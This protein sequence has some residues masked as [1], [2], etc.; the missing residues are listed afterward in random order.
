MN[1]RWLFFPTGALLFAC[2]RCATSDPV[3]AAAD[4]ASDDA[5]EFMDSGK[6][7]ATPE[8]D[9]A[10]VVPDAG[11][12]WKWFAAF[13]PSCTK[14]SVPIDP[15]K[16]LPAITWNACATATPFSSGTT[17]CVEWDWASMTMPNTV[18]K[19]GASVSGDGK[20]L[21][22]TRLRESSASMYDVEEDLYRVE[23]LQ[24]L[25][26]WRFRNPN[27][28][29]AD[30]YDPCLVTVVTAGRG[31]PFLHAS[32]PAF[33]ASVSG[34]LDELMNATSYDRLIPELLP[35]PNVANS[36]SASDTVE[37]FLPFYGE[38]V[39]R[40]KRSDMSWV[41][42]NVGELTRPLVVK[43][44]VFARDRNTP[45]YRLARVEVNGDVT[46]VRDVAAHHVFGL[47]DDGTS[48]YWIELSGNADS[49]Q[50]Q[51]HLELWRSTYTRD[52]TA[53]NANAE[54]IVAL[55]GSFAFGQLASLI[56]NGVF[57]NNTGKEV[58]LVRLSDRKT[59]I[60]A[61]T[62][63]IT[64]IPFY[65]DGSE[66]WLKYYTTE[67]PADSHYAKVGLTW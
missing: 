3:A 45:W 14:Y 7:D 54:K 16:E 57:I 41:R 17:G 26:A 64:V 32:D 13:G 6:R 43:D 20:Y 46:I 37:A 27:G 21:K 66:L 48:L 55:D 67:R 10:F 25:A 59:K 47:A 34:T 19:G 51:P 24:P 12:G 2:V 30:Q 28:P 22:I 23:S 15:K 49:T 50:A 4:A 33:A 31:G 56:Y 39:I 35:Y 1:A 29:E 9:A 11:P 8:I 58:L 42:A 36:V 38:H 62:A 52:I 60:L 5:A 44:D 65:T 63:T 61:A 53:F 18:D 40:V